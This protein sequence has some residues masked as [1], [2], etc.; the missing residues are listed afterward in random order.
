MYLEYH[1]G[2]DPPRRL[3][4]LGKAQDPV[5]MDLPACTSQD[6][7]RGES[8]ANCV[9][10]RLERGLAGAAYLCHAEASV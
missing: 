3:K 10:H 7:E 6:C 1:H 5:E 9:M 4:A 8:C 2:S